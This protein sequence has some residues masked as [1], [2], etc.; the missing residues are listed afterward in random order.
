MF[1]Q[2][3][4]K[5]GSVVAARVVADIRADGRMRLLVAVDH[6]LT[7]GAVAAEIARERLV[8]VVVH[9]MTGHVMFQRCTE[10]T[11]VTAEQSVLT[12]V[13]TQMIPVLDLYAIHVR[14]HKFK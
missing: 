8:I 9:S 10:R 1:R 2:L 7:D 13:N 14:P 3:V 12:E 5:L 4:D 6:R 11:S